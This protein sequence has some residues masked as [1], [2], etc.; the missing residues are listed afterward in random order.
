MSRLRLYDVRMSDL[1]RLVGLCQDD[2][3]RIA[4][5]VNSAQERLTFAKEVVDGWYG[6]WAEIVF[7]VS[8]SEP[9]IT[10]PPE[11]AR[12]EAV[13]VCGHPVALNN[14]WV[15]YLRFG[16]GRMP[17]SPC[18]CGSVTA[19]YSRNNVC[20][21]KQMTNAPQ[22]IRVYLTDAR[23]VGKRVL[24]QGLDANSNVIY[25]TDNLNQVVGEF[26]NLTS[27]FTDTPQTILQIDGI[28]KDVTYGIVRFYQV[29]PTT[30]DQVLLL[31][32]QP[33]EQ[34]ASYR[35]YYFNQLPNNCCHTPGD[36]T[37]VQVTALAK[38]DL[39]PAKVD[40]DWLLIQ[41]LE[42]LTCEAQ[43]VHYS[44]IDTVTA[45]QMSQE[46]HTQAIRLLIGQLGHRL[47]INSPAVAIKPF[48]SACLERVR[49][50]MT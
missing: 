12:L 49:I 22:T 5:I 9:Y 18:A 45:K 24:L 13:D 3:P 2:V 38:L 47:G 48:G 40:T 29:D 46:R 44:A 33:G 15:E 41:S 36:P 8:R 1:P 35:R 10:L 14:Q 28:Q 43:A 6:S 42:A 17:K 20:T 4:S 7:N 27:P 32:M 39:I 11:I 37:T 30:G 34:T 31:T 26:L 19:A 16:N 21:F 50:G 23:D 25:S